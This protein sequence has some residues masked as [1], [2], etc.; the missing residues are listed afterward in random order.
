MIWI[1]TFLS[2]KY[3]KISTYSTLWAAVRMTPGE[4]MDAP[5]TNFPI[6]IVEVSKIKQA[7]GHSPCW[8]LDKIRRRKKNVIL[9]SLFKLPLHLIKY[10]KF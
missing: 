7:W 4:I 8:V 2:D 6:S 3:L 1:P 5:P 9:F 10:T